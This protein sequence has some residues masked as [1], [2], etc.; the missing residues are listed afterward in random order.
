[1][2]YVDIHNWSLVFVISSK[3]DL[4]GLM[5]L[6]S[7]AD[8]AENTARTVQVCPPSLP[9]YNGDGS[10]A[11]PAKSGGRPHAGVRFTSPLRSIALWI[12]IPLTN[13]LVRTA[14]LT[15]RWKATSRLLDLHRRSRRKSS[16]WG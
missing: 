2:I 10:P 11:F 6:A 13:R 15:T 4:G 16:R 7:V 9:A 1:M 3:R 14:A 12:Q 8:Y 5:R